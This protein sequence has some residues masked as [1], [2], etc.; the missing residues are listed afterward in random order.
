MKLVDWFEREKRR[1][2]L[3]EH[4]AFAWL[5]RQIGVSGTAAARYIRGERLPSKEQ[6]LALYEISRGK[7]TPNDFYDLPKKRAA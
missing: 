7:V 4:G 6:M 2:D 1:L 5:G 3:P